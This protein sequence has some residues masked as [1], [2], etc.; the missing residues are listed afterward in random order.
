[1]KLDPRYAD[2]RNNLGVLLARLG[3]LPEAAEQF[4]ETLKIDPSRAD[5]RGNLEKL[6]AAARGRP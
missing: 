1:V 2:A 6:E 3:R 5:A 4:R